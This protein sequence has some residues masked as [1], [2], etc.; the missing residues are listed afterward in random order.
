[1]QYLPPF[2]TPTRATALQPLAPSPTGGMST[3]STGRRTRVRAGMLVAVVTLLGLVLAT[4]PVQSADAAT[5]TTVYFQVTLNGTAGSTPVML[6]ACL[7][8]QVPGVAGHPF[9]FR[10]RGGNFYG[11]TPGTI[12]FATNAALLGGQA[13][14]LATVAVSTSSTSIKFDAKP[15]AGSGSYGNMFVAGSTGFVSTSQWASVTGGSITV[16]YFRSGQLVGLM[17]FTGQKMLGYSGSTSYG[18]NITGTKV[19]WC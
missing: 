5:P 2:S 15:I 9:D 18:A 7:T 11:I 13:Q 4:G 16:T 17:S 8:L 10:L 6:P 1:M 14:D 19:A 12:Q 3:R